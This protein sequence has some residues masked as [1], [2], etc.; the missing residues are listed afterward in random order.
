[1]PDN[2][3]ASTVTDSEANCHPDI[4]IEDNIDEQ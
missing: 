3:P 2:N 4:D 1:V